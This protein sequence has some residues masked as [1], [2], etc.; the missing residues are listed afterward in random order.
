MVQ[1]QYSWRRNIK[2]TENYMNEKANVLLTGS[3]LLFPAG[4]KR[5]VGKPSA[6][7]VERWNYN[8]RITSNHRREN[9][10]NNTQLRL[11]LGRDSSR[12]SNIRIQTQ[13]DIKL[14]ILNKIL[15]MRHQIQV[16]TGLSE[17][18]RFIQMV[19]FSL[20]FRDLSVDFNFDSP[21]HFHAKYPFLV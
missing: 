2:T 6:W 18:I 9:C 13:R 16:R 10:F 3:K 7:D 1:L 21:E 5:I 20:N 17:T 19:Q 15:S 12:V 11:V 4:K 14:K 8:F